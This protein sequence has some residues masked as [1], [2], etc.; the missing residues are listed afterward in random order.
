MRSVAASVKECQAAVCL[1]L[2]STLEIGFIAT[3]G[4]KALR[5]T[6]PVYE[7]RDRHWCCCKGL[8]PRTCLLLTCEERERRDP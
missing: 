1:T 6:L 7:R 4:D 3:S 5:R 2:D 8:T